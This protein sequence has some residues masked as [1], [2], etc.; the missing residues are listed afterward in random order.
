MGAW[1]ET[2]HSVV[3]SIFFESHPICVRGL[4]LQENPNLGRKGGVAPYM[5]AWIETEIDCGPCSSAASHPIWVRGLK[6][7]GDNT[8]AALI[9]SHPIWVR[10][11]KHVESRYL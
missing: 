9:G 6:L 7:M 10:G 3:A 1:I 4:K 5:G 11:L 2:L 8:T